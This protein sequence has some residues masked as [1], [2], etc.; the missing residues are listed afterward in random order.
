MKLRLVSSLILTAGLVA[1]CIHTK[2]TIV[3]DEERLAVEFENDLAARTFYEAMS[4]LPDSAHRQESE[5]RVSLPIIFDHEK[6]T[7]LGPNI[8]FN[9][10]VRRCDTNRDGRI[11]ESEARIFAEQVN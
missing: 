9:D 7:V 3:R 10:S 6:K 1:G 5:S 8:V 4:R 11:T 2:E